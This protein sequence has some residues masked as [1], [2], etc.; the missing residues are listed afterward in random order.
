MFSF[1]SSV[2]HLKREW[3]AENILFYRAAETYKQLCEQGLL[4]VNEDRVHMATEIYAN[5]IDTDAISM[6]CWRCKWI[7]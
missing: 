7:R 3:S 2:E 4:T 6:V 1:V 5:F